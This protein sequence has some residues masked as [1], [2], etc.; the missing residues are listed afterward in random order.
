[1]AIAKVIMQDQT[2]N[3]TSL[4]QIIYLVSKNRQI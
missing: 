1:M 3:I 4:D 2:I